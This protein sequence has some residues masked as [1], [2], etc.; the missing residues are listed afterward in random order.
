MQTD[1]CRYADQVVEYVRGGLDPAIR[2]VLDA[3]I[4]ECGICREAAADARDVINRLRSDPDVA[5]RRDQ[6]PLVLGRLAAGPDRIRAAWMRGLAAA[7]GL[8]LL[9]GGLL[10]MR[11]GGPKGPAAEDP[12][13]SAMAWMCETQ[14]ADGS[15]STARWGGRPQF[16]VALTGLALMA[17]LEGDT[18]SGPVQSAIDRAVGYLVSKQDETGRIGPAFD[19]ELYNQGIATLALARACQERKT[20]SLRVALDRSLNRIGSLQNADGGWGYQ[21]TVDRASNLSITLWQVEALRLGGKLGQ[22]SGQGQILRGLRWMTRMVSRN[23][24]FGYRQPGDV[25]GKAQT[26][27]AMGAMSLS[28]DVAGSLLNPEVS[29]AIRKE[30]SRLADDPGPDMDYYRRYFLAAALKKMGEEPL[31]ARQLL[32]LRERLIARQEAGG[33]NQGSWPADDQW[34]EAGG[35][36]YATAMASL[37]LR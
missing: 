12:L 8:V 34:S 26:L 10:W 21:N 29:R 20:E 5:V 23:G 28:D 25:E 24:S 32:G 37:A 9:L 7:A 13:A 22:E 4:P 35:R 15:W 19:A 2:S 17:M 36:V 31:V 6:V 11:M 27:T 33:S 18:A 14:E 16:E 30:V 1:E 3:H